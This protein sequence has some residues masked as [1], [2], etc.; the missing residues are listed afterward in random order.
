M[1][2]TVRETREMLAEVESGSLTCFPD[3]TLGQMRI[4]NALVQEK[5]LHESDPG[6]VLSL[7]DAGR[8]YLRTQRG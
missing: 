8:W 6:G 4:A 7:T 5:L 3:T 1:S 2:A